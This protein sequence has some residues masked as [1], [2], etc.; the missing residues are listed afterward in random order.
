MI[1]LTYSTFTSQLANFLVIP[2]GDPNLTQAM[3][4]II[5]DAEQRAY[6]DLDLLNT[7]F[8][9]TSVALAAGNRNYT[10]TTA[11]QGNGPFLV[12]QELNIITPAGQTNPELGTR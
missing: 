1:V 2:L 7:V 10:E 12:T 4:S 5:D 6:R 9:D 3:P 8:R 11:V